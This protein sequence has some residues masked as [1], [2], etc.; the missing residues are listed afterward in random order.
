[1]RN[2]SFYIAS[3]V[4][5]TPYDVIM[6]SQTTF[7]SKIKTQFCDINYNDILRHFSPIINHQETEES[8]KTAFLSSDLKHWCVYIVC[9]CWPHTTLSEKW[10]PIFSF[11]L[12][13]VGIW[14]PIVLNEYVD[15]N[16]MRCGL[17]RNAS[18]NVKWRD[19]D[20]AYQPI[21]CRDCDYNLDMNAPRLMTSQCFRLH[22]K[23]DIKLSISHLS[24][25]F[26]GFNMD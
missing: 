18:L 1:M 19:K 16:Y 26:V 12:V 15:V 10:E 25:I 5:P 6:M 4:V 22:G 2:R 17:L 24:S 8:S 20:Y 9:R 11:P 14:L 3:A 13:L 7:Q 21:S 23:S